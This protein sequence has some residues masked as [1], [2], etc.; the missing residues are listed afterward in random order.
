MATSLLSAVH[1][2]LSMLPHQHHTMPSR[3]GKC[4]LAAGRQ[5][6]GIATGFGTFGTSLSPMSF[7][8]FVLVLDPEDPRFGFNFPKFLTAG[9]LLLSGAVGFL[10]TFARRKPGE[11]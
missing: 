5:V 8:L 2:M 9:H 1:S 6:D 4:D 7:G 3:I 11:L 10:L